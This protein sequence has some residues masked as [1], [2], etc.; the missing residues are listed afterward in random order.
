MYT[1][2]G[3]PA[4]VRAWAWVSLCYVKECAQ[5]VDVFPAPL[6][7]ALIFPEILDVNELILLQSDSRYPDRSI[8]VPT[9]LV[10]CD[11]PNG[12]AICASWIDFASVVFEPSLV[13]KPQ[14]LEVSSS[15]ALCS[16]RFLDTTWYCFRVG[17]LIA[18]L[19]TSSQILLLRGHLDNQI[20]E[21]GVSTRAAYAYR[22][23]C[24][25]PC[26]VYRYMRHVKGGL[27]VWKDICFIS[28]KRL[29]YQI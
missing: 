13:Q 20:E 16:S 3:I 2:N 8:K 29:L 23:S 11:Y 12:N 19:T 28:V 7:L 26:S 22:C 14:L 27:S 24:I 15:R 9:T 21:P 25:S 18:R 5:P 4:I 1:E 10:H 17:S 6:R